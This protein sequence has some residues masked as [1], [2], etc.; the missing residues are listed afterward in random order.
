MTRKDIID[1]LLEFL[2]EEVG[3]DR[4][5]E[6]ESNCGTVYMHLTNGSTKFMSVGESEIDDDEET[7]DGK[8]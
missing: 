7:E 4:I 6:M 1:I 8:P 5:E 3:I 2:E